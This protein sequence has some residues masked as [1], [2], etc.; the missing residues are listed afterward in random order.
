MKEKSKQI[1]F[2]LLIIQLLLSAQINICLEQNNSSGEE[3]IIMSQAEII[4]ESR[5]PKR[6]MAEANCL[7]SG[8]PLYT[9]NTIQ[10]ACNHNIYAKKD[11]NSQ[12]SRRKA[13]CQKR[14]KWR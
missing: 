12:K 2:L 4:Q 13:T 10:K 1:V 7:T 8:I 3:K 14:F 6:C 5:I 9:Y 11:Y